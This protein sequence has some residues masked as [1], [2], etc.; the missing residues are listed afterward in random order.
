MSANIIFRQKF[1]LN[2]AVDVEQA[3]PANCA[4]HNRSGLELKIDHKDTMIGLN[5]ASNGA[6]VQTL[7]CEDR[8]FCAK[9]S[10]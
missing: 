10:S 4:W 9:F 2:I 8:R 7:F 1:F 5:I 3:I 6:W